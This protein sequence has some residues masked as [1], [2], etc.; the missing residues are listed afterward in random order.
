MNGNIMEQ[1]TNALLAL[2]DH[3]GLLAVYI[4]LILAI[5]IIFLLWK[6]PAVFEY[7]KARIGLKP[8]AK[9]QEA[10]PPDQDGV[11]QL[12]SDVRKQL[13]SINS[14]L[15]VATRYSCISVIYSPGVYIG[16]KLDAALTYFKL[17]GNGDVKDYIKQVIIKEPNGISHWNG[18]VNEDIRKNGVSKDEYYIEAVKAV[19]QGMA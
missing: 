13:E 1:K 16:Y 18:A 19:S 9:P 4:V 11:I 6:Q 12:L 5:G 15:E 3:P 10:Q 14:R 2:K 17:H 8:K 7:L